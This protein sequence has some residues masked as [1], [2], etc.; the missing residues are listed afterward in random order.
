MLYLLMRDNLKNLT[1]TQT[2]LLM[3]T[4]QRK[5]V[6][7]KYSQ[8]SGKMPVNQMELRCYAAFTNDHTHD[9]R[10]RFNRIRIQS[11]LHI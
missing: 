4:T 10:L 11:V 9:H 1:V 2:T 8:L 5:I 6:I 3:H 7:E